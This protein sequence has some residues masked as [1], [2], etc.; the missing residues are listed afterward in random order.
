MVYLGI[1]EIPYERLAEGYYQTHLKA[2]RQL[3]WGLSDLLDGIESY[4]PTHCRV[5]PGELKSTSAKIFMLL[6]QRNL[7]TKIDDG[8]YTINR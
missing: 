1:N 8:K 7:I 2:S 3:N 4:I 5:H 6:D